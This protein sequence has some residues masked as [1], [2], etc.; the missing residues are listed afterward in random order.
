MVKIVKNSGNGNKQI[1]YGDLLRDTV[2]QTAVKQ[3][4][5]KVTKDSKSQIPDVK[6]IVYL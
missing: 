4:Y 2:R 6:K 3:Y 5:C 1:I